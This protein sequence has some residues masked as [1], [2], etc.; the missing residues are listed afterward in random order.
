MAEQQ[1]ARGT[2]PLKTG[3]LDQ[4]RELGRL[5]QQVREEHQE[6][7]HRMA[8]VDELAKAH[9]AKLAELKR[10]PA[11]PQNQQKIARMEQRINAYQAVKMAVAAAD[12]LQASIDSARQTGSLSIKNALPM[13]FAEAEATVANGRMLIGD[14]ARGKRIIET[15]LG[16]PPARGSFQLA[17]SDTALATKLKERA[18]DPNVAQLMR[19]ALQVCTEVEATVTRAEQ[20]LQQARQLQG[21]AA[22]DFLVNEMKIP[23]VSGKLYYLQNL[24][25]TFNGDADM[26]SLFPPPG[27]VR[28]PA[29]TGNLVPEPQAGVAAAAKGRSLT[30][31]LK[32]MLGI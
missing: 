23:Q 29:R 3:E 9:A 12:N 16:A 2:M 13:K 30:D 25:A 8:F 4:Q 22:F 20:Q 24:H 11:S 14:S 1:R 21:K 32:G 17:A 26:A 19:R 6:L 15:A 10:Q 18:A 27:G 31:K 28:F 5:E 7:M